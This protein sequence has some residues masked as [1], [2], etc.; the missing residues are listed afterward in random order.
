M[1]WHKIGNFSHLTP[2]Y[3]L[4]KEKIQKSLSTVLCAIVYS[5][6]FGIASYSTPVCCKVILALTFVQN[7]RTE[8]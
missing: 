7:F 4:N 2:K 6:D 8:K 3:L 1:K 5:F